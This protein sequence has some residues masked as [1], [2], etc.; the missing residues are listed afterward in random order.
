[1]ITVTVPQQKTIAVITGSR[2]DWGLLEPLVEKI[3]ADNT[4]DMRLIVTGSHLSHDHGYTIDKIKLPVAHC[5]DILMA[6]DKTTGIVDAMALALLRFGPIFE[7]MK[8]DMVLVL[9]DRYEIMATTIAAHVNKIPVAHIHGGEVTAGA[10]DDAFRHSITKMAHLHFPATKSALER[11]IRLGEH[12]D[13]V[14]NVGAL[15]C[16]GLTPR[17]YRKPT[18]D[19]VVL[20]HPETMSSRSDNFNAMDFVYLEIE[21]RNIKPTFISCGHDLYWKIFDGSVFDVNGKIVNNLPRSEFLDLLRNSD[22][23]VGNSSAGIIEAPALG[24]PT[25][26]IGDRQKG[27]ET[28]YSVL[29]CEATKRGIEN[30]FSRLYSDLFQG[31]ISTPVFWGS[32]PYRGGDVSGKILAIIK[33]RI[34]KIEMKKGFYDLH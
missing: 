26:N 10:Y 21:K 25:L 29:D 7:S 34:G 31:A 27:R 1:M 2:A 18:G 17:E 8:P 32:L 23:I 33:E 24:V 20:V 5:V 28:A 11:I 22:A 30:V 15:G 14:F 3:E 4:L 13:T 6:N 16:D 19:I 12:P 9:G